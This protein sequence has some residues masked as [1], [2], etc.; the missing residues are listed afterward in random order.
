[1]V[2]QIKSKKNLYERLGV[3]RDADEATLKKAY[4]KLSLKVHP[5]RN[6][7]PGADEAFKMLGKA[8]EVLNEPQSRRYYDQTGEESA[9]A[10]AQ[11]R[12]QQN[13]FGGMG[14]FQRGGNVHQVNLDEVFAQ[15]FGGGMQGGGGRHRFQRQQ[16]HQQ[17]RRQQQQEQQAEA[18]PQDMMGQF[19]FVIIMMLSL[20]G[21]SLQGGQESKFAFHASK[22]FPS[23]RET[24]SGTRVKYYVKSTFEVDFLR[25]TQRDN[26]LWRIDYEVDEMKQQY[27]QRDC[28]SEQAEK[29]KRYREARW[30]HTDKKRL[31]QIQQAKMPSCDRFKS[32]K[33]TRLK[34]YQQGGG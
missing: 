10:A 23:E 5:D 16:Q 31:D 3:A 1:M 11:N 7:A 15:F 2:A 28:Q 18:R 25:G 13:P 34:I 26:N 12:Q 29:D 27:L 19:I 21:T 20:F 30:R 9:Q 6:P 17:G 4:R 14:G 32:F 24:E 8:Y 33:K 22:Q